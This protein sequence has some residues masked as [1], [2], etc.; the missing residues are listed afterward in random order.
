LGNAAVVDQILLLRVCA[1]VEPLH[2]EVLGGIR[3]TNEQLD[4]LHRKI[5]A[6]REAFEAK[7]K[8]DR[9]AFRKLTQAVHNIFRHLWP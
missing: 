1:C 7:R 4:R 2:R 8:E 9:Y 3:A 5:V 6:L